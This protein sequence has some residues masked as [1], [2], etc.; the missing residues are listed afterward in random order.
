MASTKFA[1]FSRPPPLVH[2][3][4]KFFHPLDLGRPISNESPS[5]NDIVQVNKRN[6]NKNKTKSRRIQIDHAF[7]CLIHPTNN[8]MLSLNYDFTV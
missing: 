7:Y 1:Q 2:L 8:A 6:Q 3:R 5:P 4:P